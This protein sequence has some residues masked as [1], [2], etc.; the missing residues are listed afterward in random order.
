MQERREERFID[1]VAF[2]EGNSIEIFAK[3]FF[4]SF[5]WNNGLHVLL[6]WQKYFKDF[7]IPEVT[8]EK[9]ARKSYGTSVR[10]ADSCWDKKKVQKSGKKLY[11]KISP[12]T[13][14][15]ARE[16]LNAV[17]FMR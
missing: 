10:I 4:T 6:N 7:F 16:W 5:S 13:E 17:S 12:L 1:A 15:I 9:C 3:N 8:A 2:P 11:L 14:F